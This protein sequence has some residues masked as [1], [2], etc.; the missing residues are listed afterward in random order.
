MS[1]SLN[2]KKKMRPNFEE[3][4]GLEEKKNEWKMG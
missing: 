3:F 4:S 2:D 1:G